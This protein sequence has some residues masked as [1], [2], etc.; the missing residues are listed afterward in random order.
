MD[1][2]T[3]DLTAN[4][5]Q[6]EVLDRL[7][8]L[9]TLDPGGTTGVCYA[10]LDPNRVPWE[11]FNMY[12]ITMSCHWPDY[13]EQILDL[14][15]KANTVGIEGFQVWPKTSAQ[16]AIANETLSPVEVRGFVTGILTAERP[17]VELITVQ[18]SQSKAMWTP[19]GLKEKLG[20]VPPSPHQRDAIRVALF[21]L[22][23]RMQ[24]ASVR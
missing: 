5:E 11:P 10:T 13:A 24:K 14:L 1:T 17:D 7:F 3:L 19:D 12:I 21:I 6:L 20:S 22:V 18:P 15:R 16:G 8:P 23:T 4:E 2:I 9:V